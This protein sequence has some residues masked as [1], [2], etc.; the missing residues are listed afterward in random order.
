LRRAEEEL[1]DEYETCDTCGEFVINFNIHN[2]VA[3]RRHLEINGELA[4]LDCP[5]C[6]KPTNPDVDEFEPGRGWIHVSCREGPKNV[7]HE[8][9]GS[10]RRLPEPKEALARVIENRADRLDRIAR[11]D[12]LDPGRSHAFAAGLR[13]AAK[14]VR[15]E[16]R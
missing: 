5:V 11:S 9:G 1:M 16:N 14:M 2:R 13:A 3:F 10:R 12:S 4:V 15:E 8:F 7:E 6:G